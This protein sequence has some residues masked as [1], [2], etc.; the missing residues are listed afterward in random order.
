MII[1]NG[2]VANAFREHDRENVVFFASGVSN[3]L[4]KDEAQFQREED[5][6][7]K[8]ISE[9]PDV[10]FVYFSSCSIYDSSKIDSHYVNHKLNMEHL[11]ATENDKYLIARVSNAVGKGGNQNTLINYLI[12][13]IQNQVE[14]K[15]HIDATRNQIDVYDVT[16]IILGLIDSNKLN[17]IVNV[18][19]VN[20][21]PILEIITIVEEFLGKKGNLILEKKGQ[22]YSID[23]PDAMGYFKQNNLLDR[24][25][26][27]QGILQK[28]Y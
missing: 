10:L 21:Y 28:Y 1:G 16:Q 11:I 5:L 6:I 18:A 20:N 4:E 23:I 27:L 7:R 14:I 24:E 8:T 3:S 25:K 12:N 13:S 17:K 15:V 22:G 2:L 26:Y 9:N 19:Y